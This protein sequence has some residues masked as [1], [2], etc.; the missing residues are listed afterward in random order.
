MGQAIES[1]AVAMNN[2]SALHTR[3]AIRLIQRFFEMLST[4]ESAWKRGSG[5]AGSKET[6]S[7]A[8]L[9]FGNPFRYE[10][11]AISNTGEPG[12][13]RYITARLK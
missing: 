8:S 1:D 6:L 11:V 9:A 3:P 12:E 5:A 4:D 2:I 10:E 7:I 13:P